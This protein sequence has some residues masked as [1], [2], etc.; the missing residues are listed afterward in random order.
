MYLQTDTL[1]VAVAVVVEAA[2]V[3]VD[4]FEVEDS[5]QLVD[6]MIILAIEIT[7]KY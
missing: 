7:H 6:A 3:G 1:P 5:F 4:L 2:V